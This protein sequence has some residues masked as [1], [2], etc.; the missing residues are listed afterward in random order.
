MAVTKHLCAILQIVLISSVLD[1]QASATIPDLNQLR[2]LVR[3]YLIPDFQQGGLVLPGQQQ[4]A[5]AIF[6][7]NT[8]WLLFRYT[9]SQNNDGEK[10]VINPNNPL[11]PPDERTYNNYLAARPDRG[12]HSEIQ[13][14]DRLD[15][16]Y[17]AYRASH[18]NQAPKALLLYSWIVPC[19]DCTDEIVNVFTRAPFNTITTK[20]V[21][22]TTNGSGSCSDCDVNYTENQLI[23]NGIDF[24]KV[25]STE[26]LMELANIM[27][28]LTKG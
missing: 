7:P 16:L 15:D 13:I 17:N 18:N 19:V 3:D 23:R 8:K 2:E 11:S 14:L 22:Y 26:Q 5:V 4:F 25:Y 6:Q 9:P 21:A 20:V 1:N 24:T 28:K 27:A 10:P 12:V